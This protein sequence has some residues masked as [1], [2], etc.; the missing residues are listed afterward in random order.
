MLGPH[1]LVVAPVRLL[2]RLDQRAAYPSCEVVASQRASP[3][4]REMFPFD[5]DS[6]SIED[7][8]L[9]TKG[10]QAAERLRVKLA[11]YVLAILGERR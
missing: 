10:R 9:P 6:A 3:S 4:W 11:A 7:S 5:M 1:V 8:G 2:A